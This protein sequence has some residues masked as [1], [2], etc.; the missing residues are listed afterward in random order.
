MLLQGILGESLSIVLTPSIKRRTVTGWVSPL[1]EI[2]I[3][4]LRRIDLLPNQLDY[5]LCRRTRN[6]C[7]QSIQTYVNTSC[8]LE[9]LS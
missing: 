8:R 7:R 3:P 6:I 9:Y 1:S 2:I 4:A 5:C